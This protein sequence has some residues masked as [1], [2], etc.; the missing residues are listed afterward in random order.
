LHAEKGGQGR[1]ECSTHVTLDTDAGKGS[2]IGG[3]CL[4][5]ECGTLRCPE[6][7]IDRQP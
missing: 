4:K 6:F 7:A 5:S 2:N 1:I 3:Q